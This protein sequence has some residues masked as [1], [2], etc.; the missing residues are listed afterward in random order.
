MAPDRRQAAPGHECDR[1]LLD[2]HQRPPKPAS[3]APTVPRSPKRS[4]SSDRSSGWRTS[5]STTATSPASSPTAHNCPVPMTPPA[6]SPSP[7]RMHRRRHPQP[8]SRGPHHRLAVTRLEPFP[9]DTGA[10]STQR[11][12]AASA[13]GHAQHVRT[14]HPAPGAD[15]VPHWCAAFMPHPCPSER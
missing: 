5:P 15:E 3:L 9:G 12:A 11:L 13:S 6:C 10:A 8:H 2:V 7:Q 1:R 14:T 4:P